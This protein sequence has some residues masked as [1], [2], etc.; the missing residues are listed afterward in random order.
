[1]IIDIAACCGNCKEWKID[2][3]DT[4]RKGF[5]IG[6]C[7]ILDNDFCCGGSERADAGVIGGGG[8]RSKSTFLCKYWSSK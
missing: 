2:D 3:Y 7:K 1:M 6:S 5:G 4:K 8:F